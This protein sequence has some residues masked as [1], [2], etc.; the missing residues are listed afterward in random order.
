MPMRFR[1]MPPARL[2][3][4]L[5][6]Y[7]HSTGDFT[8]RAGLEWG[9]TRRAGSVAGTTRNLGYVLIGITGFGQM[10][11]HRLAWL[12]VHGEIPEG[13]E[14]DHIDGNPSNNAIANLRLASSSQQKHN[15][16]VQSNNKSGLKGAY[17]HSCKSRK[18]WRSQI[19]LPS[20]KLV[21]L[22]YFDTPEEAHAAY[23]RACKLYFGDFARAA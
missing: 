10:M 20:G 4:E 12:Y 14:V 23:G 22:G 1:K 19:K 5:L 16:R 7:N 3:Q 17:F 11:A 2:L 21:F 13:L 6:I 9:R 15:K 8:W 18:K